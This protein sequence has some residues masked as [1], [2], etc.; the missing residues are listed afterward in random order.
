MEFSDKPTYL[1]YVI[2][3]CCAEGYLQPLDN[4]NVRTGKCRG[5][6]LESVDIYY[7]YDPRRGCIIPFSKIN[8]FVRNDF[9]DVLMRFGVTGKGFELSSGAEKAVKSRFTCYKQPEAY[10]LIISTEIRKQGMLTLFCSMRRFVGTFSFYTGACVCVERI[11]NS[12]LPADCFHTDNLG[13][14]KM[15]MTY[16]FWYN[17]LY[18]DGCVTP[19]NSVPV[20]PYGDRDNLNPIVSMSI[21][22]NTRGAVI[23]DALNEIKT[24]LLE[25]ETYLKTAGGGFTLEHYADSEYT[26]DR[27]MSSVHFNIKDDGSSPYTTHLCPAVVQEIIKE[28]LN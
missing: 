5:I 15:P 19:D 27:E 9:V 2:C 1:G 4:D 22:Y 13:H 8:G 25:V 16:S 20:S 10:N 12:Y 23:R 21:K 28:Y 14:Q 26:E 24:V 6:H 18:D 3:P 7:L 11:L 17:M